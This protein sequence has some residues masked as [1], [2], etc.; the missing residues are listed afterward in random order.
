MNVLFRQL[1][2]DGAN[3]VS[4]YRQCIM[5]GVVCQIAQGDVGRLASPA[6]ISRIRSRIRPRSS[7]IS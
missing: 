6:P 7:M 4:V 5:V 3:T 1:P 2:Y